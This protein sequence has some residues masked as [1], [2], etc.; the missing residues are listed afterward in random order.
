MDILLKFFNDKGKMFDKSV[1]DTSVLLYSYIYKTAS[2]PNTR[3]LWQLKTLFRI[4]YPIYSVIL[5]QYNI[6]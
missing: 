4:F 6:M 3:D 5:Y 2:F 1:I